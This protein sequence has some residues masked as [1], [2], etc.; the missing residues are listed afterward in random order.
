MFNE[1]ITPKT[2]KDKQI[3]KEYQIIYKAN[4][5]VLTPL[6]EYFKKNKENIKDDGKVYEIGFTFKV[7]TDFDIVYYTIIN[8]DFDI[9]YKTYEFR[10]NNDSINLSDLVYYKIYRC[11]FDR[12]DIPDTS[13][14]IDVNKLRGSKIM[15][16]ISNR[17]L[18]DIE[19]GNNNYIELKW[20][21]Y[22]YEMNN[23]IHNK[24]HKNIIKDELDKYWS[25]IFNK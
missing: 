19:E 10:K 9:M 21:G 13:G 22:L 25:K 20:K 15:H 4:K 14:M 8:F 11:Y 23:K 16:G 24:I 18:K 7:F 6:L 17:F 1:I 3:Q 2:I 5:E 12:P